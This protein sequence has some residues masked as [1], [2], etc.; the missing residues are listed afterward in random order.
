MGYPDKDR[1]K[2]QLTFYDKDISVEEWCKVMKQ[3]GIDYIA[4]S[5]GEKK[6]LEE[7]KVQEASFINFGRPMIFDKKK[8]NL[9]TYVYKVEEL[10]Q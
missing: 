7:Y 3:E 5:M 10:C 8:N 1:R 2:K 6:Y 4:L 9:G